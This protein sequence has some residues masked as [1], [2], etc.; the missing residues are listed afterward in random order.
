[1]ET[2]RLSVCTVYSS[3]CN[4]G[5][6]DKVKDNTIGL[7]ALGICNYFL[8]PDAHGVIIKTITIQSLPATEGIQIT[9]KLP[10]ISTIKFHR[11]IVKLNNL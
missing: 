2:H 11:L 5:G 10:L 8:N 7:L 9:V 6:K 3:N 1:M 4:F